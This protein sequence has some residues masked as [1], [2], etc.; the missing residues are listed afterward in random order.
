MPKE[1]EGLGI[2]KTSM[3]K[4]PPLG[5]WLWRFPKETFVLWHQVFSSIYGTHYK[6]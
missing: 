1:F 3:S 5:K 4:P 6:E 2:G